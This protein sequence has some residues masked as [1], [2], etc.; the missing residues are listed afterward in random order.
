MHP[1]LLYGLEA[2]PLNKTQ[3]QS[4]DFVISRLFIKI[5]NTFD[6]AL[7]KQCQEQFN[8]KLSSVALEQPPHEIYAQALLR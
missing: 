7:V 3:T 2:C 8:F 6:I 4:L 5:F 1:V